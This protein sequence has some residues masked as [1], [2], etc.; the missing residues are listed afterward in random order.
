[1]DQEVAHFIRWGDPLMSPQLNG[2]GKPL[3]V[4]LAKVH[5][6]LT[7][8]LWL[9]PPSLLPSCHLVAALLLQGPPP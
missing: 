7:A 8:P 9:F 1:M 6:S 5:L 4:P 3:G 2:Q